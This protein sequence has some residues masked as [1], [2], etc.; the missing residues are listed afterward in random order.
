[1]AGQEA[2]AFIL[3]TCAQSEDFARA[4][5]TAVQRFE[6]SLE[7]QYGGQLRSH[8]N[9]FQ[10]ECR[11]HVGQEEE[12]KMRKKLQHALTQESNVCQ[13]QLQKTLRQHVCQNLFLLL[14]FRLPS[15]PPSESPGE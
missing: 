11:E 14:R 1:M 4:E 10:D 2:H 9:A 8:K 3:R 7:G 15:E 13:D 6:H 12:D 5:L